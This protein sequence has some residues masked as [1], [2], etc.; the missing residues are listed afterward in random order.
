MTHTN[1][2]VAQVKSTPGMGVEVFEFWFLG[3]VWLSPSWYPSP[4]PFL[5]PKSRAP[6]PG[7]QGCQGLGVVRSRI[8]G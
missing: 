2:G 3:W 4:V 7:V 6:V 1:R 8:Q 5:V